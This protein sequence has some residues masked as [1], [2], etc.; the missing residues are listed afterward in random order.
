[1]KVLVNG[2]INLS[3][4]DGWWAEAYSP[5]V[6]WAL[7][8]GLDHGDDTAVDGR[9]AEA[10]YNLIEQE[11][12]P[13]FYTRNENGVPVAWV[14]K[15]RESMARL[16]PR[17][18]ANRAVREYAEKHYLPAALAFGARRADSGEIG[19]RA[20]AWRRDLD[21]KWAK[22][23]FGAMK[24]ET[25]DGKH[26]FEI[27]V[28]LDNLDPTTV[29]VELYAEG[30]AECAAVRQE[31]EIIVRPAHGASGAHIYAGAVPADRPKEDYTARVTPHFEGVFVP[32]ENPRILWQR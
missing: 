32:L 6:G 13:E 7:G 22:L 26:A 8:D 29:K 31:M 10:L 9:E 16:T 28:Y 21:R 4:L 25:R 5:D 1:M 2:G 27:Q 3:E 14:R 30:A 19:K 12:A 17:F 15:L 20:V 23:H 24:I 11:I 18:S